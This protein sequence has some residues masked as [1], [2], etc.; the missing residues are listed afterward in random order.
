VVA[1][2]RLTARLS[3]W[4]GALLRAGARHRIRL[5][6]AAGAHLLGLL[7]GVLASGSARAIELPEDRADLMYHYYDGAG[8]KA[9]GPA[10]L[11]RKSLLDK[12]SLFGGYYVDQVSNASI[13]VVTTASKYSETRREETFGLDYVYRDATV[14]LSGSNSAEPDYKAKSANIDVSQEMFANMTTVSLGYTRAWDRVGQNVKGQGVSFI[15][16]VKHWRYRLGLTQVLTPRLIA[17]AN[18]EAVSDDGLLSSPYRLARVGPNG[19][20]VNAG[21][22]SESDPR[23][24]TSR[25]IQTRLIG[26]LGSRD[27]LYGGYRY[28][29]DTWAIR[30]HTFDVGYRRYFGEKWLGDAYLRY[31]KQ[32]KALFYTDVSPVPM[33]YISRNRQLSTFKEYGLGMKVAYSAKQVPGKYEIKL[34]GALERARFSYSDF[35]DI[36]DGSRF[37]YNHTIAQLFVTMT[38]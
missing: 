16:T 30:A 28:F 38:Y 34:N 12:V 33:T 6:Y 26:D 24:R 35:T 20:P 9:Y 8:T 23:T 25:A 3:R 17:S 10:L 7:A 13:D 2:N 19:N 18:F 32:S 5:P 15:D 29:W 36:R 11:V 37:K 27:A 31:Y 22:V 14:T 1:T 4:R 21:T